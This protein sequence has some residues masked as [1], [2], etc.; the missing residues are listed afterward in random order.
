MVLCEQHGEW[1]VGR[2]YMSAKSLQKATLEVI[3]SE[4]VEEVRGELVAAS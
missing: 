4:A 3:E 2:A 1:I